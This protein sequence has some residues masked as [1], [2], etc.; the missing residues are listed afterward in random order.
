MK[1]STLSSLSRVSRFPKLSKPR[2]RFLEKQ[3]KI[4]TPLKRSPSCQ[5]YQL[6]Q[7]QFGAL[8]TQAML[9]LNKDQLIEVDLDQEISLLQDGYNLEITV[10]MVGVTDLLNTFVSQ[11]QSFPAILSLN[12]YTAKPAGGTEPHF[13]H[14]EFMMVRDIVG[15]Q[16]EILLGPTGEIE[17]PA[18]GSGR[19]SLIEEITFI[20]SAQQILFGEGWAKSQDPLVA[21]NKLY[22]LPLLGACQDFKIRI[23]VS[24]LDAALDFKRV[25]DTCRTVDVLYPVEQRSLS[26][27]SEKTFIALIREVYSQYDFMK[28]YLNNDPF[29]LSHAQGYNNFLLRP[30][31]F[32]KFYDKIVLDLVHHRLVGGFLLD[33]VPLSRWEDLDLSHVPMNPQDKKRM[34]QLQ[35]ALAAGG[36]ETQAALEALFLLPPQRARNKSKLN[37]L[38]QAET[39]NRQI[40]E[41]HSTEE[42]QDKLSDIQMRPPKNNDLDQKH[43]YF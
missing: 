3:Q 19:F 4:A 25:V 11:G 38:F 2:P 13:P 36:H 31:A 14:A 37:K 18:E 26:E 40:P 10:P 15:N 24:H 6:F 1:S 17:M 20:Y 27:L 12:G 8:A 7:K 32:E 16:Y 28:D 9:G 21:S 35:S 29:Q 39:W 41:H 33:R 43:R 34:K 5:A 22:C 30:E 42:P 23:C